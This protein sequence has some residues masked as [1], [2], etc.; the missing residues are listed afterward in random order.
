MRNVT[1]AQAKLDAQYGTEPILI[2]EI[3]WVDGG[4]RCAY[5]DRK[6]T[7]SILGQIVEIGNI[8]SAM[9]TDGSSDSSQVKLTLDDTDGAIKAICD[10]HDLHKRP[11]WVYQ[12]FD[13]LSLSDKFL[14]FKGE[15]NS[16]FSWNEGDRT[17]SFDVTTKIEDVEA[18]FSMEEGDFPV[19]PPDALGKPW[20][21]VF[22]SVCDVKATQ[23]RAPRYGILQAGEAIH[24]YTLESRICQAKYIQCANVPLGESDVVTASTILTPG[25]SS[26]DPWIFDA[27]KQQNWGPDQS[28][29][30]DRF[31]IICDLMYQLQQQV[32]YEHPT[33]TIRGATTLF[34][35]NQRITINIE[36]GKFIGR[37]AGDVFTIENREHPDLVVNPPSQCHPV[38]DRSFATGS[39]LEGGAWKQT[40]SG[41]SWYDSRVVNGSSGGT[42]FD[43]REFTAWCDKEIQSQPGRLSVGG[44]VDSRKAYDNMA[45]DSLFWARAGSKVF[46]EAEA[47][48]LYIVN[49]LPSTI[50]RVA[51][52]K[53]TNFGPKLVTV[54][55]EFY[56]IYETN[57]GGYTVTE[58]GMTKPLSQR[59]E[60]VTD[61]DGAKRVVASKWSDD[62]YV[63]L[64]SSVPNPIDPNP[65]DIIAWLV[66]QYTSLDVDGDSFDHVRTRL[67]KYPVQFAL[68]E[69]KNVMELIADIAVQSRCMVYVRD[70][71]VY[72]KYAS[73]EPTL[74]NQGLTAVTITESD[75]LANTLKV[76]LSSTDDVFT[77]HVVTWS[78]SQ[79][80]GELKIVLKHN[81]AK[82]GTHEKTL[83]YY[84][85]NLYDNVLKSATF[86]MIRD[87]NVW[88]TVEFTTPLKYLDLEVFDCVTLD[89]S[90]VAPQPVKAVITAVK[91]DVGA[92]EIT[93]TCWTPLRAGE[94]VPYV[95]AWPAD[96]AVGTIFPTAEERLAG[97]G[98]N[99]TVSPPSGHL[100]YVAQ[101]PDGNPP[102]V[103]TSGDEHP[104][105]LDDVLET[106][107]C[108]AT[109][110]AII[111]ENDPII[112]TLK[113][114]NRDIQQTKIDTPAAAGGVNDKKEKEDRV[115]GEVLYG[116]AGCIYTVTVTYLTANLIGMGNGG[117]AGPCGRPA[118]TKGLVCDSSSTQI[119]HTFTALFSASLFA[120]QMRVKAQ[121]YSSTPHCGG[122][123]WWAATGE[124]FPAWVS[125]PTPHG[126][127][128]LEVPPG[129]QNAPNQGEVRKPRVAG[130]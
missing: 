109:D 123:G 88:K 111:D 34:P 116:D 22:G 98:Y 129:N 11:V 72:L 87:A 97:L 81:V 68:L 103:L 21:L 121:E 85:Q 59:S 120:S 67:E 1:A 49:L 44:P 110:D 56:T 29:V 2:V 77:K 7:A 108:P 89:L 28:C 128:C 66:G 52:M 95:H 61:Q 76:G 114:A 124:T 113:K 83:A 26:S 19:I 53:Q 73:E 105:D 99:F 10:S 92:E 115:C 24:D 117:C 86:W 82:Y 60:I 37:F 127:E 96:I 100:L 36:G 63:T 48:V 33:M 119:C 126:S 51:A 106:C 23:V 38:N 15:I 25:V 16:P 79:S 8:D 101:E 84:T 6:I 91:Y 40:Q 9:K 45:T 41:S 74:L 122:T 42:N 94:A 31:Y 70:D 35:Q 65:V 107:F 4:Q 80:E 112:R 5:A 47:E 27:A 17:V 102:A 20:P 118:S 93:F 46:L 69:R 18:G 90:D 130:G 64:T 104:S 78:R 12:W 62:L 54:P 13:G 58:I 57:Y 43:P 125:G 32:S 55:V 30:E 3:Q 14:L 50:T 39:V 75:V 71:V